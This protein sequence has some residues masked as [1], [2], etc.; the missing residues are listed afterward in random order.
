MVYIVYSF[1]VLF[2]IVPLYLSCHIHLTDN[3]TDKDCLITSTN[4][5]YMCNTLQYVLDR[6]SLYFD[7]DCIIHVYNNQTFDNNG[8]IN[9][10]S[11]FLVDD[12]DAFDNETILPNNVTLQIVGDNDT[13]IIYIFNNLITGLVITSGS[14]SSIIWSNVEFMGSSQD[15]PVTMVFENFQTVQ[16]Y[17]V[18]LN[19]LNEFKI[20]N[21][22]LVAMSDSY[23]TGMNFTL[24]ILNVDAVEVIETEFTDFGGTILIDTLNLL[25]DSCLFVHSKK[26]ILN[27]TYT[28]ESFSSESAWEISNSNFFD[29]N[30]KNDVLM[31]FEGVPVILSGNNFHDNT[32]DSLVSM[33]FLTQQ[34]FLQFIENNISYN[35]FNSFGIQ[36]INDIDTNRD[37]MPTMSYP[38]IMIHSNLFDSNTGTSRALV[39]ITMC[40]ETENH[41][42][43]NSF[44]NNKMPC[45]VI[46]S[47]D[48]ALHNIS[49]SLF[50]SNIGLNFLVDLRTAKKCRSEKMA[51]YVNDLQFFNNSF[52]ITVDEDV[53]D[54]T[55]MSVWSKPTHTPIQISFGNIK[56][57]QNYGTA[58]TLLNVNI[59]L[60]GNINFIKNSGDFGGA[61]LLDEIKLTVNS[62]DRYELNFINNTAIYGGAV[63]ILDNPCMQEWMSKIDNKCNIIATFTGNTAVIE[64]DSVY[65]QLPHCNCSI[66]CNLTFDRTPAIVS[67]AVSMNISANK[68]VQKS[69]SAFPGRNVSL[70][71]TI[72]DCA[73]T[74]VTCTAKPLALCGKDKPYS[75]A[76]HENGGFQFEIK[77]PAYINLRSGYVDTDSILSIDIIGSNR[78]NSLYPKLYFQCRNHRGY[79]ITSTTGNVNVD[80]LPECPTGFKYNP[81]TISC[82]CSNGNDDDT[83]NYVCDFTSGNICVK[84]GIWAGN[85][86]VH[87]ETKLI[88]SECISPFC[89]NYY[90]KKCPINYLQEYVQLNLQKTNKDDRCVRGH[91]G[92]FCCQCQ[93]GKTNSYDSYSCIDDIDCQS[94]HQYVLLI[95]SLAWPIILGLSLLFFVPQTD[96][97]V[98]NFYCPFFVLSVLGPVINRT[99]F[100]QYPQLQTLVNVYISTFLL[101]SKALSFIPWCFFDTGGPMWSTF[102]NY[103]GPIIIFLFL[104]VFVKSAQICSRP[105][106]K[107]QSN[108][109][110]SISLTL[111]VTFW[112]LAQTS[113][114]LITP[115]ELPGLKTRLE[116]QPDQEY[117]QKWHILVFLVSLIVIVGLTF[118]SVFLL[119]TSLCQGRLVKIKP[120]LDEFQYSFKLRYR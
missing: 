85:W 63:Y 35:N 116:I 79:E 53:D 74:P 66:K 14:N 87:G 28:E 58:L 96:N 48:N 71:F 4:Q 24:Y 103:I 32:V 109:V 54:P 33:Q 3:S 114:T 44:T 97:G 2:S 72:A 81:K 113:I 111:V 94:W 64:G 12:Y 57:V 120:F 60:H 80:I 69:L 75:C 117:F 119:L 40:S 13:N 50:Q 31:Y 84:K 7:T 11:N 1:I 29:N 25:I 49:S 78:N 34:A 70:N 104:I 45:I 68:K 77:G 30:I 91:S 10:D 65:T 5:S 83:N 20:E 16:L 18:V 95:L 93:N 36:V 59:S 9:E 17:D 88:V 107:L 99:G 90:N 21:V 105:F 62:E 43:N 27:C 42:T 8:S 19:D 86:D 39:E 51:M 82:E 115:I 6:Y 112:S 101:G 56:F 73:G 106:S 92:L 108:P 22:T 67:G 102:Y 89:N 26:N 61:L 47:G 46:S 41:Y 37:N 55:V 110:K 38:S 98:G 15:F 76:G 100:D 23:F 52:Y 118:V